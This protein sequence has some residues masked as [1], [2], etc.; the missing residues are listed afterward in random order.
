MNKEIDK[1]LET[2]KG[3]TF[4]SNEDVIEHLRIAINSLLKDA[5]RP[6][7]ISS[8]INYGKK[9]GYVKYIIDEYKKD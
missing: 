3:Q 2:F 1:L 9:R 4:A 7:D 6:N 5:I 8:Y